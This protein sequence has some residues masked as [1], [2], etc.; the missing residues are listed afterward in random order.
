MVVIRL[1][2]TIFCLE[3]LSREGIDAER[4]APINFV[5]LFLHDNRAEGLA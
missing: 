1:V 5:V 3:A 2:S 4:V